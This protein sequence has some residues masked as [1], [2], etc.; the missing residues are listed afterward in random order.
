MKTFKVWWGNENGW[1][2]DFT[3]KVPV[4]MYGAIL[5]LSCETKE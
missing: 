4:E 5:S 2:E 1:N 3:E